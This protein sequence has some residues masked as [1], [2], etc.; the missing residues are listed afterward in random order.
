M[1]QFQYVRPAEQKAAIGFVDREADAKFIAGGTN[2][3]DLMKRHV[4]KP[5]RLVD[6]NKLPLNE[7]S[8][9]G[10]SVMIGALASNTSVAE[11]SLIM[12]NYPCYL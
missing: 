11:H 12:K 1:K 8:T 3:L 9:D 6:I 2:L 5:A 10:Q 4:M 7:I